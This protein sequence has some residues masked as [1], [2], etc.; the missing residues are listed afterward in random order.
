MLNILGIICIVKDESE[1]IIET[2]D[3]F[4]NFGIENILILDTGSIDDT[5]NKIR[6][7]SDKIII[8]HTIFDG[9][10]KS[11]NLCLEMAKDSFNESVKFILMIDIEWYA[12][13]INDLVNFCNLFKDSEYDIFYIDLLLDSNVI[14]KKGCLFRRN[15][16]GHYENPIHEKIIGTGEKSV[17]KF[18]MKVKQTQYGME[19]TKLRNINYDIPYYLSKGDNISY[20]DLF[21]L[22]Q[23]YHNIKDY[24]K[25]INNYKKVCDHQDVSDQ[26]K[27]AAAYRIGEIGLLEKKFTVAIMGYTLAYTSSPW[28]CESLFR[29]SQLNEGNIKYKLIKECCN[30][31]MT[32]DYKELFV[33][34]EIYDIYRYYELANACFIIGK[35]KEGKN[36]I[37][38]VLKKINSIHPLYNAAKELEVKLS[39]KIVILILSSPGY[40][41]FNEVMER[42]FLNFDFEFYFYSFSKDY[43]EITT[44]DHNIYIPGNETLIPGILDKTLK[45]FERF[46][47]Y[48]YII[49]LNST[50]ILNLTKVKFDS[51]YWGYLN[52][53]KLEINEDYGITKEF[54]E[55][56][57]DLKF[58]S[59][60]CICMSKAAINILL[61]SRIEK[62]IMDDI[63]ISLAMKSY[64]SINLT[65]SFSNDLENLESTLISCSNIDVMN[66]IIDKL[67]E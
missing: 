16:N 15:G 66:L 28:R 11:R 56:N 26:F 34:K 52:S 18:H 59:G 50:S 38:K 3:P 13:N 64:Y 2:F 53:I 7:M 51:N 67:L 30:I 4:V 40:E 54:L 20:D 24:E 62:N 39:T 25:A 45:V 29:L 55:R 58:I 65:N 1:K 46:S 61:N 43:D 31:K 17:P 9:F 22:A 41:E 27:Y 44:V 33:A 47:N 63:Y 32:S 60:K 42:Y 48:D 36:E 12:E 57:E 23:T 35:Y 6:S 8:G 37:T 19:K 21:H 5:C 14:I 49:R 10:D